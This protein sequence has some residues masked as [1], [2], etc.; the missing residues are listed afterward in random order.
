[1]QN[2]NEPNSSWVTICTEVHIFLSLNFR[3]VFRGKKELDRRYL[4]TFSA[5]FVATLPLGAADNCQRVQ[6]QNKL[7]WA[8]TLTHNNSSAE[9]DNS[10]FLPVRQHPHQFH[11]V[12]AKKKR[13]SEILWNHDI[14][15]FRSSFR[16]WE[17]NMM[18]KKPHPSLDIIFIF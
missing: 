5:F 15:K 10:L 8:K 18:V 16:S 11:R 13:L 6:I 9:I 1:M 7:A 4:L 3:F 12:P 2:H 17:G 14:L